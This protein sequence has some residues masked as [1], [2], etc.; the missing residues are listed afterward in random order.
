VKDDA[1]HRS[2]KVTLEGKTDHSNRL[3]GYIRVLNYWIYGSTPKT[4]SEWEARLPATMMGCPELYELRLSV[5]ALGTLQRETMDALNATP[6]IRALQIAMRED[7]SD[8]CRSS[9]L[10]AQI[11]TVTSWKLEFLIMHGEMFYPLGVLTFPP[12]CL[13]L[14]EF[15][16]NI[17]FDLVDDFPVEMF[18]T[19][20]AK[21][22]LETL[23]VLHVTSTHPIITRVA[24]TLRSLCVPR[25][26]DL[27]TNLRCLQELILTTP[28]EIPCDIEF[29]ASLPASLTHL[30]LT[31]TTV[32]AF[33]RI[34]DLEHKLPP[35]LRVLS[36]YC[37]APDIVEDRI[38]TIQD[39]QVRIYGDNVHTQVAMRSD[40]VRSDDYPR[41][42]NIKNMLAMGRAVRR[43][44]AGAENTTCKQEDA[45]IQS[46]S[47]TLG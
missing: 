34:W 38:I 3:R 26:C 23:E 10:P 1:A 29:Y 24:P 36:I 39:V 2:L 8:R 37:T 13:K 19:S 28:S 32:A 46:G 21:N 31:T 12:P 16:W 45:A 7:G 30:G 47:G 33:G 20:V 15:R 18:I 9:Y 6:P 25:A 17:P 35:K 22:S 44:D 41:G 5:D 43:T 11:L 42:I 14:R 40:L 4:A 27:P